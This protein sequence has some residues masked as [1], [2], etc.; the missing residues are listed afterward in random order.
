MSSGKHPIAEVYNTSPRVRV[1]PSDIESNSF[2][3]SGDVS[4]KY[5]DDNKS[6]ISY[7]RPMIN[8]L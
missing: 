2:M 8:R 6:P 5:Y 4:E 7:T 3:K 1:N